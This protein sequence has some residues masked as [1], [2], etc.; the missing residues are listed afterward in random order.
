MVA[1]GKLKGFR[2]CNNCGKLILIYH[3]NRLN[4]AYSFCCKKCE[5]EFK[6]KLS[7]NK[8]NCKCEVCGKLFHRRSSHTNKNK[9]NFCSRECH[10]KFKE[11]TMI[12]EGNHQ[13]GLKGYKNS[14]WKSNEY[15]TSNGYR[16]IYKPN[17]PLSDKYGRILEHRYVAEKFLATKEELVLYNGVYVLNPNLDVHHK[18]KNKLNNNIDNLQILTRSEHAKLHGDYKHRKQTKI[19]KC[20]NCNNNYIINKSRENTSLFCCKSCQNEYNKSSLIEITCPVCNKKFKINKHDKNKRT[21]CSVECS[22]KL[23]NRGIV[24][25]K[26]DFCGKDIII[27]KSRYDKSTNHFCDRKCY[28]K[29]KTT[30]KK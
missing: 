19:L 26:C 14:S 21:C 13:Y 12:G 10:Y 8:L 17:H 4:R 29:F 22:N 1:R 30:F 3:K 9:H 15:I 18:D 27:K 20:K 7:N 11:K 25:C 16:K 28:N 23:R 2:L 6:R 24:K 5:G